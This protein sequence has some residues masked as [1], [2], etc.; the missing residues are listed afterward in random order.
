MD[1]F[2]KVEAFKNPIELAKQWLEYAKVDSKMQYPNA[3]TLATV[4]PQG[5]P[6]LRVVLLKEIR[7][8]G[9]VF[10]TNY[11]SRKGRDIENNTNVAADFYWDVPFRQIKIKGTVSKTSREDSINYWNS[12]PRESQISQYISIQS[13]SA[14]NKIQL[15]ELYDKTQIQFDKKE[16]PCPLHWGGYILIPTEVIFWIG[17][18][19]RFHDVFQFLKNSKTDNSS[20][21]WLV[22]RLYP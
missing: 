8:E 17:K 7:K 6:S 3:M 5:H 1:I 13:Q 20:N 16:I 18:S 11:N 15:N 21:Y 14:P 22:Q 4:N 10:Y 9:F 19:N 12:R 2:E